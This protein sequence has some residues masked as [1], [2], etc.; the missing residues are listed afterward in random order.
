VTTQSFCAAMVLTCFRDEQNHKA[1]MRRD[2][3][4][5]LA[6]RDMGFSDL[7]KLLLH[8]CPVEP[9]LTEVSYLPGNSL[10]K[11]ACSVGNAWSWNGN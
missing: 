9:L 2:V 10:S 4:A 1:W 3:V 11:W 8:I 5:W 7:A 6:V